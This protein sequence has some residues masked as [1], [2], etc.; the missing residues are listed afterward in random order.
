MS[1]DLGNIIIYEVTEA[2]IWNA[3]QFCPLAQSADRRFTPCRENPAKAQANDVR[4][5][6][7]WIVWCVR[8][9]GFHISSCDSVEHV[10]I[11]TLE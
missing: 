4:E 9:H 11:K 10:K 3:A 7:V 2:V 1:G 6:G 8:R 5:G